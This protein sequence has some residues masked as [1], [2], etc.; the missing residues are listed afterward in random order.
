MPCRIAAVV[1]TLHLY[2]ERTYPHTSTSLQCLNS[3]SNIFNVK[4][5]CCKQCCPS[6][7]ALEAFVWFVAVKDSQS[8]SHRFTW[9]R[10]SIV[11]GQRKSWVRVYIQQINVLFCQ[12]QGKVVPHNPRKRWVESSTVWSTIVNA[13]LVSQLIKVSGGMWVR[14]QR[15]SMPYFKRWISSSTAQYSLSVMTCVSVWAQCAVA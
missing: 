9:C 12:L 11:A 14:G 6:V 13:I 7:T 4:L 1:L 5:P 15:Y 10:I 2:T 3:W 8:R